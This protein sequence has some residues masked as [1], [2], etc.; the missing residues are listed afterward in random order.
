MPKKSERAVRR[1]LSADG[2]IRRHRPP[3]SALV[4]VLVLTVAVGIALGLGPHTPRA[5]GEETGGGAGGPLGA[6]PA[7]TKAALEAAGSGR[8]PEPA[9]T[10]PQVA[11]E[12]PH[13]DLGREEALELVE[14]VF[15]TQLEEP[16]GIFDDLEATKF[17]SDNAAV[18]TSS[19]LAAMSGE[20]GAQAEEG[21]P[22]EGSVLIESSLPLR[23]EN[24]EGEEEAVDL[25]LQEPEA[26]GEALEPANPLVD[27]EVPA[28][29]GEGITLP[30][31]E[32]GIALAGAPADQTPTAV[33]GQYAFYPDVAEDT[34]LAVSPTP[35]GVELMT[36][37]RSAEAPKATTYELSL[38]S[39]A[40]LR[41]SAD[42][43]VEVVQ[44]DHRVG[45]IP[46]PSA[47]DAA[48]EPVPAGQTVEGDRLT[49][50]IS[51]T[52]S[53]QYPVLVDP[54]YITATGISEEWEWNLDGDSEGAWH[55]SNSGGLWTFPYAAW[56]P[57]ARGLDISSAPQFGNA[58]SG[59]QAQWL[60]TVPRYAEDVSHG[61]VPT[62]W[63]KEL[64]TENVQ[65]W[66]HGNSS[67]YPAMVI[68]LADPGSSGWWTDDN[69]HYGSEGDLASESV[70]AKNKADPTTG[71]YDHATKAADYAYV[72]YEN[73]YPAKSRDSYIGH[74]AVAVVDEDA[75]KILGLTPPTGWLTGSS[76]RIGYSLED[77]GLGVYSAGVRLPGEE[78]FKSNWIG[79]GC[80]GT[81]ESPCPRTVAST[82]SGRVG[83]PFVP[84]ELP[85]GEDELEVADFDPLVGSPGH[86]ASAIVTVKVDNEGPEVELSGPLTEEETL[87][88]LKPE[89]PLT[90]DAT[91]GTVGSPQSGVKKIELKVDGQSK[92]VWTP[93]C[94]GKEDCSFSG[95]W[96]LKTSE[97]TAGSHEVEIVGTDALGNVSST[98]LEV[99]L[100]EAP[101]QTVFTSPHPA[102]ETTASEVTT[103]A[104]KATRGGAPVEGAVFRCSF[105]GGTAAPCTSPYELPE[106]LE[107]KSHTFTVRA[108]DKAG[109]PDPTPA[110]WRFQ[111]KPYPAAPPNEKLVY[112]ETGKQTASYYTL[113]AEWGAN[114]EGKAG[115]GVTGVTFQVQL[116]GWKENEKGEAIYGSHGLEP[117]TFETVPAGCTIDGQGRPVSWPLPVHANPGHNKPVYLKVRG[118]P[119]FERAGYP[120]R[121]IEFRAVFDG[122]AKVA[123]ASEPTTTE[124]VSRANA[125]RVAT[126]ATEAVGP[127]TLDLLTGSFTM[128]RTDVSIP[129]PGY[130]ANLE[131]TRTYSSTINSGLK[132]YSRVLGGAWQPGSPLESESEGEAW[133]R[134]VEQNIPYHKAVF[135]D[136]CWEEFENETEE[137][138]RQITCP[139]REHCT[140]STCEE[141]EVEPEQPHEEWIELLDS[142]GAAV[143]FE[144]VGKETYVAPEYAQELKLTA[145]EGNFVLAYP[146]GS[147]N[148]FVPSGSN[149]WVP[150]FV[151]FQSTPS[152]MVMVYEP[153][154]DN[155]QR[156]VREI[157]PS[158]V[159][160]KCNPLVSEKEAGCRTLKFEYQTFS[161][162]GHADPASNEKLIGIRYFGPSGGE[163]PG[164]KVA[165][166]TY[167]LKY[168]AGNSEPY[169]FVWGGYEQEE[170]L[171]GERD[172]RLPIP[173][174]TYS[175]EEKHLYGNLLS[176]FTP[177]GQQPWS[178]EYEYGDSTKP[179]RL[180]ALTQGGAKTT[181]AYEVPV[182]GAGAP[183]DMSSANIAGWGESALPVDA[184]AIF[185]PNHVPA[186]YPPHSYA[187]ATIHYMNPE[188][189]EV[190]TAAPSPPGVVGNTISTTETDVHGDVIRELDPQNRLI[191][192][193]SADPVTRS[194]ELDSH[195][196]YNAKGTELLESWG[197]LHQVRI[198]STGENVQARQHTVTSYDEGAPPPTAGIPPAY[199]PTKETVAG[200]IPGKEGEIE[201]EVTETKYEWE[202]RKPKETIVD[203]EG[204]AIRTVTVYDNSGKIIKTRQP[205]A[206]AGGTAGETQIVYYSA[207][208][209]GECQGVPQ[210][211]NLPCKVVPAAQASGTG[212]P[213]LPIKKFLAYN[214]LDEPTEVTEYPQNAPA[215]FRTTTTFYD[216]AGREVW[217][218]VAGGGIELARTT[219]KT[220]TA[221]SPTLGVPIEQRFHCEAKNCTGFDEQATKTT[222]NTLG[223]VT[224]YEDADGDVTETKYDSYGRPTTTKDA[225]GTQTLHYDEAS[226][227]VTSMEVTGVGTFTATYD[228]DGDLLTQGMP[229]GLSAT[230]TYN[231]AGE[232]TKLAYTKQTSCGE[233]CTWYEESLERSIEGRILS[234]KSSLVNDRYLY[235]KDGRLA[236]A[237]ETPAGGECTTRH[238]T[239][240]R[241]SNRLT[242]AIH[243][244]GVGGVCTTTGGTTQEYKYDN[245][246]RL[247]GPTYD[248]WGRITS[249]P[250]EFAGGTKPLTTEYFA[251]DMVAQQTQNGVTN[252]FQLD[253]TGRQ[254]QREQTG[255]VAG[256]E[257]FHYD[258]S[259]D[260]PAWTSLG[261]TW[262]RN[263][264]GIGG[265]LAAVQEST[266]TTTFK[267]T[268]LHGDVVASA[269]S[270]PT[271]TKLLATYRFTE[272]G[273]PVSGSAS[274]FGWLGGKSRRTELASGV[275]QMGARSY[276]PSLGRFLTPDPV[277]GGSANAYDYANQDPINVFDLDGLCP[278]SLRKAGLCGHGGRASNAKQLR[279]IDRH[280]K[281][282][283]AR[284]AT[285]KPKGP[286]K[287]SFLG[288]PITFPSPADVVSGIKSLG[289]RV[290]NYL[291][292]DLQNMGPPNYG[293]I[294]R[295]AEESIE[296][297]G[298]T[299]AARATSCG[300]A[301][302]EGATQVSAI[303]AIPDG[304]TEAAG[305]YVAAR[306][307]IAALWP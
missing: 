300:K 100:G 236:E 54:T 69:V 184:T 307:A 253:A 32:V 14:G 261:T 116:P 166:Y 47:T 83:I 246:D 4:A 38:P 26:P 241:D 138:F 185:P 170:M 254:R 22:P 225:R 255:G 67:Y 2:D 108:F 97:Y 234:D 190:N 74:A 81:V 189:Y 37:I 52:A 200:V 264:T 61:T 88:T 284:L 168:T 210:Y 94:T 222:Y 24:E 148:I 144:V 15:A 237:H 34:D 274:R 21:L 41:E 182:T 165:E 7:Q 304:G 113:E 191:A 277:R 40:T 13:R 68:G 220:E 259:G 29:L 115:Q 60:Y 268:D 172:P 204:L 288:G 187:G 8:A 154:P 232:P 213:Q 286:E 186:E 243:P 1:S 228:A 269:S 292:S 266:G 105:D 107:L 276:I 120:E 306:C 271:A 159:A 152:S 44:G 91:D 297:G 157:A 18:V 287:R 221:Y 180:T 195:S 162:P 155:Q 150:K 192:L 209:Q 101:P 80:T 211:A 119:L 230:T 102:Y 36:Q 296:A 193:E 235:D 201:P 62:T 127:T 78:S 188:G 153:L 43:S 245:A 145:Q 262:S 58:P 46:P 76:A 70:L 305:L 257:V 238:Y 73:E 217:T 252:T 51:P 218:K 178:F 158:P 279:R 124:F 203:P 85:T 112:P 267:L 295:I 130:E 121:G 303:A 233:S 65:F 140:I 118:C 137:G 146:N 90:I 55:A 82:E 30:T 239:Y 96:T 226:G 265:E 202:F 160:N 199:L 133:S 174:E 6:T 205:K 42:G 111:T 278:K 39:G 283:A 141:W 27:V 63:I 79:F 71:E 183:Y 110:I 156:L 23:T 56:L 64:W 163:N 114:P 142:E 134:I 224:K 95:N 131:F 263:V 169:V 196:V 50:G 197:P 176:G 223:Q 171:V 275:I 66:T 256:I 301:A 128:S 147:R 229:N 129:V 86:K 249:L 57:A 247:E 12:L 75:P 281:R 104:F 84:S 167:A 240:D 151:S 33:E 59:S 294:G 206:A 215:E 173:A 35:D 272:F 48:G 214:Y 45:E 143:I 122:G 99:D 231:Q 87:G 250:A 298:V 19:S 289:K 9:E 299:L 10:D 53:T 135:E 92:S 20:E 106:H 194:H 132:G 3:A 103:I 123:G 25:S 117:N 17:L 49:V 16:A 161:V 109:N 139:D 251:N 280:E 248:A 179:S 212:R 258:G 181:L 136:E 244:P 293:E 216:E 72:T 93:T 198:Q 125:N 282:V 302:I 149:E 260:S 291:N 273:E 11:E 98:T 177:P 164:V 126:D 219:A 175:Y 77:T 290:S 227:V 242:K 270:S 285:R 31:Q 28:H 207:T 89:Y 208:G 5:R